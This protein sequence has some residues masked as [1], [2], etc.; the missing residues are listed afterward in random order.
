MKYL[1]A[2]IMST[3]LLIVVGLRIIRQEVG[4]YEFAN[5]AMYTTA[6]L[7]AVSIYACVTVYAEHKIDKSS[8]AMT[9]WIAGISVSLTLLVFTMFLRAL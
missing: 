2:L 3:P 5:V 8:D 1:A 7:L 4:R 9:R 6:V